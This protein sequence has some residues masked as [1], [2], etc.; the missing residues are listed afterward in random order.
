MLLRGFAFWRRRPGVMAKGLIP[1]AIVFTGVVI[2]LII[3][4]FNLPTL[5]RW[6]TPFDDTWPE[7]W[8]SLIE[9]GVGLI[10][11]VVLIILAAVTFTGITL[12]VGEPFYARIWREVEASAGHEITET[13][14][15]VWA[16]IRGSA[17]LIALGM[18]TAVVVLVVGFVPVVGAALAAT[19][20]FAVSGRLLAVELT[21]RAFEARGLSGPPLRAL[22]RSIRW[23]LFG[24]GVAT[25]A[26]FLIPLGA[27]A[28][29]PSA[30]AGATLLAHRALEKE[31]ARTARGAGPLD[32]GTG[33]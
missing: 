15:G 4:G 33:T 16:T 26:L 13:G 5:V 24:F 27:I 25:Q 8:P 6:L 18:I 22:R 11:M 29:M 9:A 31:D 20:G 23:E 17:A 1:A 12:A 14:P 2:A 30:V 19:L 21:A 32:R 10:L 3:V 7:P 28:A